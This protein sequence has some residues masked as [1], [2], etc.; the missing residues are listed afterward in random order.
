MAGYRE[1]LAVE[2]D[3]HAAD[4]LRLNYPHLDV[5]HGDIA[6]LSVAE[7]LERTGLTPGELD[8]FDG[9]PPCTGFSMMGQRQLDDPRNQLFREYVRLLQG[10]QPR[11]F[12]MENVAGMARGKMRGIYDEALAALQG[13]GYRVIAGILNAG[14]LGVPQLRERLIVIGARNDLGLTPTL[15]CPTHRPITVRDAL[16]GL[17][18]TPSGYTLTDPKWLSV[19]AKTPPGKS[20]DDLHPKGHFFSYRKVDPDRACFTIVKTVGVRR[21]GEPNNGMYHWRFPRLLNVAE[22]KRLG[23]FPDAYQFADTG[24]EIDTFI[25]TWAV[26]G[27]SVPP[28]MTRAIAQHIKDTLLRR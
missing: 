4:T 15:P 16:T 11:T 1:L 6:Q 28:L 10:L 3:Q 13:A 14:Y 2:W 8:L 26:I 22:L 27:N 5:Y 12:V 25:S 7:V 21:D 20:F 19:Y 24:D 17:P 18:T 23:S 9:S